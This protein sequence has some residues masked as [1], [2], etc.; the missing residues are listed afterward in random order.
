MAP[1]GVDQRSSSCLSHVIAHKSEALGRRTFP[2]DEQPHRTVASIFRVSET[3]ST[4]DG[5]RVSA[6]VH[7]ADTMGPG[8]AGLRAAAHG[9]VLPHIVDE[10]ELAKASQRAPVLHRCVAEK[11]GPPQVHPEPRARRCERCK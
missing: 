11:P 9:S 2:A 1:I 6:G 3:R 10:D 8:A 7:A 5:G 4:P